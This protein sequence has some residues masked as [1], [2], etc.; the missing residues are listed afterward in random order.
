M[1]PYLFSIS[2][3][4]VDFPEQGTPAKVMTVV[5]FRLVLLEFVPLG[6]SAL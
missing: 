5:L 1:P 2:F 3:E 6:K 4:I